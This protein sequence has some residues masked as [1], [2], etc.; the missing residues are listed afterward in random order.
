MHNLTELELQLLSGLIAKYPLL[1]THIPFLKVSKRDIKSDGMFVLFEY[2][3]FDNQPIAE[4]MN[5]LFSNEE[6]IEIKNLK[7]GLGYVI[8]ITFGKIDYIE[9]MTYGE[10]WDGKMTEYKIVPKDI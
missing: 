10:K 7:N 1:T 5:A 2:I 6:K 4:D 9:F 3:D 8:D